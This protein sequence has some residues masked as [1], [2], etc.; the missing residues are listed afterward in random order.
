M[1]SGKAK[2]EFVKPQ[3]FNYNKMD[4]NAARAFHNHYWKVQIFLRGPS[5]LANH[6]QRFLIQ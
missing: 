2:S 1:E 4:T 6:L 5:I 3:F